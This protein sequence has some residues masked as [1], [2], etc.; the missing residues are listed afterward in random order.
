V[1]AQPNAPAQMRAS[2]IRSECE[3][4]ANPQIARLLQRTLGR[5]RIELDVSAAG[6]AIRS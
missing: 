1:C 6:T 4:F 3:A 2:Q 5:P